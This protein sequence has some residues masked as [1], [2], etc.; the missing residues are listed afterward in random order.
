MIHAASLLFFSFTIDEKHEG[1]ETDKT[2]HNGHP[3]KLEFL[4]IWILNTTNYS[5]A[6]Y[7]N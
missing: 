7:I 5:M 4:I 3:V 6:E 2:K 1:R